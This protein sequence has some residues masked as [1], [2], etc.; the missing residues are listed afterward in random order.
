M[1]VAVI[2]AS[3]GRREFVRELNRRLGRQTRPPDRICISVS[4]PEDAPGRDDAG[5]AEVVLSPLGLCAQRNTGL[6]HIGDSADLIVFFDD[7][8]V[9]ADNHLERLEA[10]F[11]KNPDIAGATGLVLR[12]GVTGPGLTYEDADRAIAAHRP[13]PPEAWSRKTRSSLYGCN[14][15]FRRR[16]IESLRFDEDL[17]LYG[18]LEDV[19]FSS[20]AGRWGPIVETNAVAGVHL[21]VKG[22]RLS[23]LRFGY[24]QIVNPVY[25]R[26]KG[27]IGLKQAADNV[28]GNFIANHLRALA[29]EPHIDR[30][31]R[32]K[33]NWLAIRDIARGKIDPKAILSI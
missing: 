12:D 13:S 25:L 1:N 10:F 18:W 7:D 24:S 17:P 16:A 3:R 15:S 4:S 5:A 6:N 26:R 20:Q 11:L 9:P 28:G 8:F 22:G 19:D 30:W 32:V 2:I 23:G 27:T 21:G 29:P 14:M 33:G 31:G